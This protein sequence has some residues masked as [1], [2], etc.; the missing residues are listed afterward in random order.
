MTVQRSVPPRHHSYV[1][2][3]WE[4]R[5]VPPDNPVTWRFSLED[6]CTGE[7][8]GF[9]SLECLVDFLQNQIEDKHHT[10]RLVG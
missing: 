7:K 10:D 2:R 8:L 4:T 6:S 5:S 1:L 3:I 9:A